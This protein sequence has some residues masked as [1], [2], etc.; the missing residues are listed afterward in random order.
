MIKA[1]S[2]LIMKPGRALPAERPAVQFA[3]V[4]LLTAASLCASLVFACATPFAAFAVLAAAMLPMRPAL[5]TM[6][7]VWLVNQTVGFALLG[8]PTTPDAVMWGIA[9]GIAAQLA[10]V[11]AGSVLRHLHRVG[12]LAAYAMALAASFSACELCLWAATPVLGGSEAFAA[13]I[14]AWIALLNA[15]WLAG[16]A[17]AWEVARL[18]APKVRRYALRHAAP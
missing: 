4:I 7:A 18:L 14:V 11:T 16:L 17:G 8:Y 9:I 1:L 2:T 3:C 10:T 6:A 5:V 13:E 12:S 15:V